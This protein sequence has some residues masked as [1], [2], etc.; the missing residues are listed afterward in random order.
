MNHRISTPADTESLV[1]VHTRAFNDFFL[2]KLGP[3]FLKTY[4][5]A[6]VKNKASIAVCVVNDE[7]EV[8]GFASGCEQANGYNRKLVLENIP[9][10]LLQAIRLLFTRP[11]AG[12]RLLKNFEKNQILPTTEIMP[13]CFQL[14]F[15]P[16]I[17]V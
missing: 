3:S 16:I 17:M 15:C 12:Y 5:K 8:I 14:Q 2:T 7:N 1:N 6:A 11:G 10:F 9:A 4:Y 13:N